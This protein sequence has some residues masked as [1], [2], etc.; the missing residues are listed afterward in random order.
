MIASGR[1]DPDL[2]R[3]ARGRVESAAATDA[4]LGQIASYVERSLRA[5]E[6]ELAGDRIGAG[7]SLHILVLER[8][9]PPPAFGGGYGHVH[10]FNRL[11][12]ARWIGAEGDPTRARSIVLELQLLTR[13]T[14]EHALDPHFASVVTGLAYLELARIGE[15]RGQG[16][17]A[18]DYYEQ[19]LRRY[20]MPTEAHRPMVEE[21]RAAYER[22]GGD[23]RR[24]D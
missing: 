2:L 20:D 10:A 13:G 17:L 7:D 3:N 6:L 5:A 21:A 18:R 23:A 16:V 4:R 15:A 12:G 11:S 14:L 19:F 1:R 9:H 8:P 24:F 22:L